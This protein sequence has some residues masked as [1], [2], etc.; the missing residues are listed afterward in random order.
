MKKS[1]SALL[2]AAVTLFPTIGPAQI[3][4][5]WLTLPQH[6]VATTDDALALLV[7]PAGL[8]VDGGGAFYFLAPYQSDGHF[9]DWGFVA[10]ESFGFAAEAL[11]S[12][13]AG[14]RRR[15]TWGLGFGE[16]DFYWGFN[17]S[18]TTGIDRQNTWDIGILERP[19]SFLSVG[20]V[21]HGINHP[22][23]Y[24][25]K[26]PI[27]WD[28][29]LG[30]R[31]LELIDIK[32]FDSADLFT[33]TLD[34]KLRRFDEQTGQPAQKYFDE[35]DYVYGIKSEIVPGITGHFDYSPKIKGVLAHD[36]RIWAGLSFN[37]G[38][39]EIGGFQRSGNGS[40]SA[41]I[42]ARDI[43]RRTWLQP[44]REKI[45]IIDDDDNEDDG[46]DNAI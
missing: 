24:G 38:D 42:A 36:A 27:A 23:L 3:H 37:F 1:L 39:M 6:S 12:D 43:D 14:T 28:V 35:I 10:G 31:P 44:I 5:T 4:P 2:I 41:Y 46:D 32:W 19:W 45:I 8:G 25:S 7:N 30:L 16:D 22:R 21:A 34:A 20:A 29:G 11:R 33:L 26:L 17:Y 13:S 40:G 18:W 9:E 15:Y